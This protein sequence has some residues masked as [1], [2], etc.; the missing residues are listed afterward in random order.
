MGHFS[1]LLSVFARMTTQSKVPPMPGFGKP[2]TAR[3]DLN[4]DSAKF[5]LAVLLN[6]ES[7]EYV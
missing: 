3:N 6:D 1:S 5:P 4:G 2:I 7:Y